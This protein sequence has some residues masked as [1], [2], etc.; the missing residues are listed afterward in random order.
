MNFLVCLLL[1]KR[2]ALRLVPRHQCTVL[3][4]Q[5]SKDSKEQRGSLLLFDVLKHCGQQL[6]AVGWWERQAPLMQVSKVFY[7]TPTDSSLAWSLGSRL[8]RAQVHIIVC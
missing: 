3:L 6:R 4:N 7:G 5:F 8:R 1:L 2:E